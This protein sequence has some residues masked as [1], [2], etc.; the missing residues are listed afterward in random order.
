MN[1]TAEEAARIAQTMQV[2]GLEITPANVESAY[3][4]FDEKAFRDKETQRYEALLWD[5]TS[6]INGTPANEVIEARDDIPKGGEVLLVKDY[7]AQGQVVY[8]QPFVPGADGFV[9]ITN[10]NWKV[11]ATTLI[12]ELVQRAI[13]SH[14][15]D[16]IVLAAKNSTGE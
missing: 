1:I 12:E 15:A 5:H 14:L 8:F 13:Q 7:E 3:A 2:R 10:K 16:E 6:D 11:S 9:K 4:N